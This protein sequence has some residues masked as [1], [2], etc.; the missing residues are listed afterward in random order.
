MIKEFKKQGTIGHKCYRSGQ[1]ISIEHNLWH[2]PLVRD[3]CLGVHVCMSVT[4]NG[5]DLI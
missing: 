2:L 3:V 1:S 4:Y 5:G